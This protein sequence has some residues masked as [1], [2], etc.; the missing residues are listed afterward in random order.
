MSVSRLSRFAEGLKVFDLSV[1]LPGPLTGLLLADM[2]AQ[3]RKIEPPTG[4]PMAALGPRDREGRAAF[5]EAVNARKTVQRLDL[6]DAAVRADFLALV[7]D[8]DVLIEGFRPGVMKRLG[9]DYPTLSAI[10]PGLIYCSLSGWGQR[11]PLEQVAGHDG[12]YLA[13]AGVLH[14]NGDDIPCV[15]DPPIADTTASLFAVIAILGAVNARRLDG[16]GC[17]IDLALADVAMPLQLFQVA[18]YGATGKVPGP[19]GSYL[20]GGAAFYQVYRTRDGRHV[21]L[22]A[23][24]AKFW[25]AFCRAAGREQWIARQDEPIP[26][27]ALTGEVAAFIATLTLDECVAR[28]TPADCCFTPVL[29][30][31]EAVSSPHH[32]ARGIVR[33]TDDDTLQALFPALI[34]G[35]PPEPR[36]HAEIATR[37]SIA[38]SHSPR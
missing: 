28:F 19:R 14:R 29:D 16:K 8:A 32:V 12:N 13:I 30:L 31:G 38:R 5:Y 36:P 37:D 11:S 21:I 22:G 15:Y 10:N 1:F 4:D 35:I 17:E 3:V 27:H 24:E 23:V 2:G 26:Q 20:N 33:R 7:C 25:T 34:D 6:K 18:G 9:L